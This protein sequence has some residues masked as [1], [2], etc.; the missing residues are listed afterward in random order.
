MFFNS[1]HE[2][3]K[4][5][6]EYERVHVDDDHVPL[7][8]P[9]DDAA[10]PVGVAHVGVLYE[11]MTVRLRDLLVTFERLHLRPV[12]QTSQSSWHNNI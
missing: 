4:F 2:N 8:A 5:W 3:L 9:E 7:F 12:G 10:G 1:K 6:P 11:A